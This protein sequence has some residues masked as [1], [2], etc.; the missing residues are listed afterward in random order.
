M[1]ASSAAVHA[2]LPCCSLSSELHMPLLGPLVPELK[3][4]NY[5]AARLMLLISYWGPI[6]GV[7]MCA[8]SVPVVRVHCRFVPGDGRGT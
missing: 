7:R 3:L 6:P 1:Y 5:H 2:V 8:R 4:G